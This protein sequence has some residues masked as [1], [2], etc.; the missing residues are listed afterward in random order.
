LPLLRVEGIAGGLSS[1]KLW[2]VTTPQQWYC[3]RCWPKESPPRAEHLKRI[4]RFIE[5]TWRSGFRDLPLPKPTFGQDTFIEKHSVIWELD[6]WLTGISVR[7]PKLVQAKSASAALARFHM[8][9]ASFNQLHGAAPGLKHRL[10]ILDD[11][12]MGML[13]ELVAAIDCSPPAASRDLARNVVSQLEAALPKGIE[14]VQR[15]RKK[16]PIQWCLRDSHIGNFLFVD[17]HVTG[18]VDFATAGITSV[19]QDIAR[20][21]GSLVPH[22]E[23]PW[24]E[25]VEV[26]RHHRPLTAD[27]VRLIFAFHISGTIGTAANWLRWR[28]VEGLPQV[29]AAITEAK[30]TD[31]AARLESLGDAEAALSAF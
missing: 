2:K 15:S 12:R 9:A 3:L 23:N 11:L 13:R 5:H 28:F 25:C 27:E 21:V 20:L 18:I 26:Y 17:E 7:T 24:R 6:S 8:A 31:L 22:L 14:V 19:S 1:A 16:V 30:L 29:D 4:H 10:E